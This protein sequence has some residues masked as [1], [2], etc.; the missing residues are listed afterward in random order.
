[1]KEAI[2]VSGRR[3]LIGWH[4]CLSEFLE[5]SL[6]VSMVH[7]LPSGNS[8][9][10]KT[11]FYVKRWTLKIIA[12]YWLWAEFVMS[13]LLPCQTNCNFTTVEQCGSRDYGWD[14][15]IP[16]SSGTRFQRTLF[17]HCWNVEERTASTRLVIP[18]FPMHC[19]GC[20]FGRTSHFC[21]WI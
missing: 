5:V 17:R 8:K 10:G 12:Q 11:A 18:D 1:M 7:F 16:Q 2:D 21:S 4:H 9:E 3:M 13:C 19:F 6:T 14:R 20:L 15:S